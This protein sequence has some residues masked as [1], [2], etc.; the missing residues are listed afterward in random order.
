MRRICLVKA[1]FLYLFCKNDL[2]KMVAVTLKDV[3]INNNNY[4]L[5][6]KDVEL[7]LDFL[8]MGLA[9]I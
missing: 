4:L 2:P 8:G 5:K 7:S 9:F 1:V 6:C 3:Y